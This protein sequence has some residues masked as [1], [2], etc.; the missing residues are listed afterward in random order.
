MEIG[1]MYFSISGNLH[2]EHLSIVLFE[3]TV[4]LWLKVL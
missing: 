1:K 4:F 2:R 3:F